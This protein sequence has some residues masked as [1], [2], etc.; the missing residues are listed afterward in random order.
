[1]T[2][3]EGRIG[4]KYVIEDIRLEAD[5]KRRLQM[6]GMTQGT[7]VELMNRKFNKA[8]I[9]RVRGTR[10]AIGRNVAEGIFTSELRGERDGKE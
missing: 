10:F 2:L 5:L 1:M 4:E 6:L 8:V 3:A 9:F 7:A